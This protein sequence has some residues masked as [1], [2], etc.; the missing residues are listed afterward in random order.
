M[1][2]NREILYLLPDVEL[3]MFSS[4][5]CAFA[6]SNFCCSIICSLVPWVKKQN[7]FGGGG[8][9]RNSHKPKHRLKVPVIKMTAGANLP[10]SHWTMASLPANRWF[11][12][13]RK[14]PSLRSSRSTTS[15]WRGSA[16]ANLLIHSTKTAQSSCSV[17][18]G[19][20][21]KVIAKIN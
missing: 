10:R 2:S 18:T 21:A 7:H 20:S 12:K 3:S 11:G 4:A 9:K 17:S 19:S 8:G 13:A 15:I 1:S 5:A 14:A 6:V 16:D